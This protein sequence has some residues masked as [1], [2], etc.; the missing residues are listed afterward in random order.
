MLPTNAGILQEWTANASYMFCAG[1]SLF[2]TG[3]LRA[4]FSGFFG[5]PTQEGQGKKEHQAPELSFKP[6]GS[7][8]TFSTSRVS[9]HPQDGLWFH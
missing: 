2:D 9:N 3:L 7:T 4:F 5:G 1:Y 8:Y 6:Y